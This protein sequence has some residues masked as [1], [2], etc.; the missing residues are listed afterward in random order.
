MKSTLIYTLCIIIAVVVCY[1]FWKIYKN[2]QQKNK[3]LGSILKA[4]S[5]NPVYPID[6][7]RCGPG[8]VKWNIDTDT[9]NCTCNYKN[10]Y[11]NGTFKYMIGPP[12][13]NWCNNPVSRISTPDEFLYI[14]QNLGYMTKA[15]T[16]DADIQEYYKTNQ[17]AWAESLINTYQQY[18]G[19]IVLITF[20]VWGTNFIWSLDG[21]NNLCC[22]NFDNLGDGFYPVAMQIQYNNS[23]VNFGLVARKVYR[24]NNNVLEAKVDGNTNNVIGKYI[25]HCRNN[26][27]PAFGPS[28]ITECANMRFSNEVAI[29]SFSKVTQ[30]RI[31]GGG[32]GNPGTQN[33]GKNFYIENGKVLCKTPPASTNLHKINI[34]VL[35]PN[36]LMKKIYKNQVT[37]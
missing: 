23:D 13:S 16:S 19:A 9:L 30:I 17:A 14:D 25:D 32:W 11:K 27:I 6:K 20:L 21:S 35:E 10:I 2:R 5:I 29:D 3:F 37:L 36:D 7:L 31:F 24:K 4:D 33:S 15:I 18:N 26:D 22:V 12:D 28:T 1:Y 34:I 8:C